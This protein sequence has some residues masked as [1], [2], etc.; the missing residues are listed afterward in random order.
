MAK[1]KASGAQVLALFTI[2]AYTA[3]IEL[4]GLKLD[5]HPQLVVSNVGSD[6]T[7]LKGLLKAFSE[8]QGA[9]LAHR[10]HGERRL[11]AADGDRPTPEALYK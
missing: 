10:R 3:L 4:A 2:P 9:S 1:I 5:Y 7:T 8:G 6:P 11:P